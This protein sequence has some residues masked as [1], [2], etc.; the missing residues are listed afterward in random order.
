ME[1]GQLRLDPAPVE[2]Y[3]KTYSPDAPAD[4]ECYVDFVEGKAAEELRSGPHW[5]GYLCVDDLVVSAAFCRKGVG[6]LLVRHVIE[7]ARRLALAGVTLETQNTN[8]PARHLYER[9]GFQLDKQ[10]YRALEPA[11]TETARLWYWALR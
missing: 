9:C 4:A 8:W 1:K 11:S 7:R 10:L 5:N 6:E 3:V 2:P